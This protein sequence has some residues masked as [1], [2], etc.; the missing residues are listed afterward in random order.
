M[1][2]DSYIV[3]E[4]KTAF[5][6]PLTTSYKLE[7]KKY[8][9]FTLAETLITLSIIGVIA[10]MTVPTLM[11]RVQHHGY[12]VALKKF[13]NSLQNVIKL[14]PENLGCSSGDYACA[15]DGIRT[16]NKFNL[17]ALSSQFK[18][19]VDTDNCK[20][21]HYGYDVAC[22]QTADGALIFEEAANVQLAS[23]GVDINGTKGPNLEGRDIFHFD[24]A[25]VDNKYNSGIRVGTVLPTG[26]KLH[27]NY[28]GSPSFHWKYNCKDNL[29]K[30]N[31]SG[32]YCTGRV[33][34][35]G[36]MDY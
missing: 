2:F 10:A 26:S 34:E 13:H 15:M 23:I 31:G 5:S 36:K 30:S 3:S 1:Q 11:T 9:G 18:L 33:L 22:F 27:A 21:K 32:Y 17:E 24:I 7:K 25:F 19:I 14:L 6:V 20:Y 4:T 12:V 16:D 8:K 29:E 28:Y 35:T